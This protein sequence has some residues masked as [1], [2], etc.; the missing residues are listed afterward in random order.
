ML[1]GEAGVLVKTIQPVLKETDNKSESCR[2]LEKI[3][4]NW[5]QMTCGS[6]Y[7]YINS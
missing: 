1:L 7:I 3:R 2:L 4:S 5:F 6:F